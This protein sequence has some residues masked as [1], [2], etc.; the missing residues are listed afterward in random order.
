MKNFLSL[1]ALTLFVTSAHAVVSVSDYHAQNA[2]K[3]AAYKA[4]NS[5][6]DFALLAG[7]SCNNDQLPDWRTKQQND[8]FKKCLNGKYMKMLKEFGEGKR[9]A[10][11]T[12]RLY[13]QNMD[14]EEE[15]KG[16]ALLAVGLNLVID[17]TGHLTLDLDTA[18][19]EKIEQASELL[20]EHLE[21]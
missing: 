10:A 5:L 11:E 18:S 6:N 9:I 15:L 14:L 19:V 12:S 16:K 7:L 2:E 3:I 8:K 21:R 13:A 20:I 17:Q 1:I 4:A